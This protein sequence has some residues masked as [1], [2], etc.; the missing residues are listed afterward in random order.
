[1]AKIGPCIRLLLL[2]LLK[3]CLILYSI[4]RRTNKK[5]LCDSNFES[6]L[7]NLTLHYLIITLHN[8]T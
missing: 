6:F 3:H 2:L 1:M 4:D 7:D 8:L 5:C